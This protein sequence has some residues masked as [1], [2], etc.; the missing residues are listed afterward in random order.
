MARVS[1]FLTDGRL[2]VIVRAVEQIGHEAWRVGQL[3][4]N[5][6]GGE[7]HDRDE[8]PEHVHTSVRRGP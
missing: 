7:Q 8:R 1:A 2:N 6:A 3:Q 5:D 4:A